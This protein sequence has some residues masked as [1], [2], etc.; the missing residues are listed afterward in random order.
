MTPHPGIRAIT[1]DA[2]FT[3]LRADPPVE[4]VYLREFALDGARG[5]AAALGRALATT[6][7]EI[8]EKRLVDRYSAPTGERGFWEMFVER[9]RLHFDGGRLSPACFDRLVEHFLRAE[10]WAVYDD[11]RPALDRLS[12]AGLR[13]A[14]VSNWDSTLAGLLEAHGL[15]ARFSALL[16]SGAERT[17][18]PHPEIFR[19]ACGRLHVAPEETLHVGDSVEED[20]DAARRAGMSAILLDRDDRHPEIPGRIRSLAELPARLAATV[21]ATISAGRAPTR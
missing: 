21:S 1:F 13:L 19:R 16:I 17:G 7:R 5:D 4:Q 18:K 11:V 14:I 3:L 10:A 2:G 20:W 9:A 6:W 12:A 8:R 15:A